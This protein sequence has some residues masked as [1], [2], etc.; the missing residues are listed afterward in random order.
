MF[1]RRSDEPWNIGSCSLEYPV[2]E[3]GQQNID[4]IQAVVLLFHL[5]GEQSDW[6]N[7]EAKTNCV[8]IILDA[9]FTKVA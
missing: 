1:L 9:N 6:L 4:E 5:A 7:L 3:G 2:G 8:S